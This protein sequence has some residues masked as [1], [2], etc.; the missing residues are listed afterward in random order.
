[1]LLFFSVVLLSA[2]ARHIY[3][4]SLLCFSSS[5]MSAS[6]SG[7]ITAFDGLTALSF[8][9]TVLSKQKSMVS[10]TK[11]ITGLLP[12]SRGLYDLFALFILVASIGLIVLSRTL[13]FGSLAL[14]P[15]PL[16]SLLTITLSITANLQYGRDIL[17][18][19]HNNTS[20]SLIINV[21]DIDFLL[22][23]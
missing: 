22:H 4:H 18:S 3:L 21:D 19:L 13:E 6:S 2:A 8:F 10:T 14:A 1:M 20:F 5:F 11:S 12:F 15:T 7:L 17:L 16:L 23:L 9:I